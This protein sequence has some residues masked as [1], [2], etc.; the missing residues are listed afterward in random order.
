MEALSKAE[1]LSLL[2][3]A[4]AHRERDFVMILVA[5]SHGLRASE[6]TR[7]Q[8]DAI[9]DG[10]LTVARLKGSLRTVQPLVADENPLLNERQVLSDFLLKA[11]FSAGCFRCAGS[12]S[13]AW[14][15]AMPRPRISRSASAT[16]TC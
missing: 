10:H 15:S 2:A 12:I 5:Y 14:C 3:A 8:R 11:N 16:R 7:M 1:L 9:A 4:R 13:G 6:V